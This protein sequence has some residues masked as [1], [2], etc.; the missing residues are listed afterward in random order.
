MPHD[1]PTHGGRVAA[2]LQRSN[3]NALMINLQRCIRRWLEHDM[4]M[5]VV[6]AG[7]EYIYAVAEQDATA[8]QEVSMFD[9]IYMLNSSGHEHADVTELFDMAK[10]KEEK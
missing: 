4:S 1:G 9:A 7:E 2:V 8:F 10:F 5:I 3:G 6:P